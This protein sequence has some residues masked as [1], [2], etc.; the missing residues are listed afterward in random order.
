MKVLYHMLNYLKVHCQP[1]QLLKTVNEML[2]QHAKLP[3]RYK[4]SVSKTDPVWNYHWFIIARNTVILSFDMIQHLGGRMTSVPNELEKDSWTYYTTSHNIHNQYLRN[5][6]YIKFSALWI[7][8]QTLTFFH[9]K[10]D[11]WETVHSADTWFVIVYTWTHKPVL[12]WEIHTHDMFFSLWHGLSA[13]R[14]Q[15]VITSVYAIYLLQ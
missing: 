5:C 6:W 13:P 4:N 7:L 14:I 11:T 10:K 9:M 15:Y 1:C 3:W 8:L 12:L 2:C